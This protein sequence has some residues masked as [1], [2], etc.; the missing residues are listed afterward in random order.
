M[1]YKGHYRNGVVVLDEP[2]DLQEGAEVYVGSAN[3]LSVETTSE[4]PRTLAERLKHVIG[5]V[6][7]MPSDLAEHHDHYAHGAPKS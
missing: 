5:G 1:V 2:A 4:K 3:P 7:D 6:K